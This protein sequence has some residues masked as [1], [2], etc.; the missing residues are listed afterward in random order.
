[1]T[2]HS[3]SSP[4]GH[5]WLTALDT[6][7]SQLKASLTGIVNNHKGD[8]VAAI[9]EEAEKKKKLCLQKRWKVQFRGKTIVLRDLFDKIIAWV[10]QFAAVVDVAVQYDPGSASLPWAGVRFLLHMAVSDRQCFESTVHSLESVSLLIARYA[11]FEALYL[12]KGPSIRAELHRGLTDLY[13]RILVFLAQGIQYFNQPTAVRLMKSVFQTSQT[14]KIDEIAKSDQEVL[15][16]GQ[17]VDSQVQQQ[18]YVQ[19]GTIRDII[20]T[21]QRPVCRLVDA[22]E[23]HAKTLEEERFHHIL[24]WLSYVPSLSITSDTQKTGCQARHSG[25]FA[26]HYMLT[27]RAR[28]P[29]PFSSSMVFPGL[30]RP[31]SSRQL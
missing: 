24:K 8:I 10:N 12:Q 27:G 2:A 28:A 7:D 20:E 5:L 25:C 11:A 9:L 22:S 17:I 16:L 6:L 13:A 31:T 19:V 29:L 4:G 14:E 23:T 21:L 15:K 3:H 1:M 18:I 30:G 26:I